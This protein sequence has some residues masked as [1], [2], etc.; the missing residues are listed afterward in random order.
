ML[1]STTDSPRDDEAL[2]TL[3]DYLAVVRRGR[4]LVAVTV[5]VAVAMALVASFVQDPVYEAEAEILLRSRSSEQLFTPQNEAS[6]RIDPVRVETEIGIIERSREVR[7]G[8]TE[9]LGRRPGEVSVEAQGATELVS[10]AAQSGDPGRAAETAN[11][12]AEVYIDTRRQARI[13]DL[14]RAIDEVQAKLGEIDARVEE[15][16]APLSDLEARIAESETAVEREA[17]QSERAGLI[18]PV[19]TGLVAVER[20]RA[21]YV[22]QLDQLQLAMNLTQTGGAEIVAPAVV[23]TSP[24]RPNPVRN[25]VLALGLGLL[26]GVGLVFMREHLDDKLTSKEDLQGASGGLPVLG[27]IPAVAGWKDQGEP[28]VVSVSEPHSP[29]AEAYRS[30]RISVQF[31]G[32]DEPLRAVQVTSANASEGKTT[33]AAN[34]AVAMAAASQRVILV[35][36]DLRRPR[37]HE[38]FGLPNVVGFTSVLLGEVPMAAAI[39]PVPGQPRVALIAAGPSPPNPSE[40]LGSKRTNRLLDALKSECDILLIDSPPVLPVADALVIARSVDATLIV[41]SAN[42]TTRKT[43]QRAVELLRQIDAP[44]KGTVLNGVDPTS[45]YPD[46]YSYGAR[47]GDDA[48]DKGRSADDSDRSAGERGGASPASDLLDGPDRKEMLHGNGRRP[49]AKPER[50]TSR[51]ASTPKRGSRRRP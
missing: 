4:R 14:Q 39:Q 19:E 25:G 42:R 10:I 12:Y 51:S 47:G 48:V 16:E 13:Q 15:V 36:C 17:L 27:L 33:T 18:G 32:L 31:T 6:L 11:T 29:A 45:G 22:S 30:L 23:P 44:L 37:L 40:L 46:T 8:V 50:V 28:R 7:D 43:L 24:A 2:V 1:P 38:F 5:G 20:Q 34:L 35:C 3:R 49:A 26:L 41:S 9:A 21:P